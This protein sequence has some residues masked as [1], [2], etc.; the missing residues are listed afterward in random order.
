MSS[1]KSNELP[2]PIIVA[3]STDLALIASE[4]VY[5]PLQMFLPITGTEIGQLGA[6]LALGI[7]FTEVKKILNR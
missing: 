4:G 6:C 3:L 2:K 5:E 7:I 1:G